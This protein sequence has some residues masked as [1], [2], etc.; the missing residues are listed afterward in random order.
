MAKPT[1]TGKPKVAPPNQTGRGGA[2]GS[3]PVNKHRTLASRAPI[4][5]HYTDPADC[6]QRC[7]Y[8]QNWKHTGGI[9][10]TCTFWNEGRQHF[11]FC[12]EFVAEVPLPVLDQIPGQ[13][14]RPNPAERGEKRQ[15]SVPNIPNP[16]ER[17]EKV[18][19]PPEIENPVNPDDR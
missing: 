10:G 14:N 11:R 18:S 12:D 4:K 19:V 5:R 15:I 7:L 2:I 16:D 9:Y 3:P 6:P 13:E 1:D 8:C 17:G